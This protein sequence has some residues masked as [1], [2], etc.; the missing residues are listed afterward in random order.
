[1]NAFRRVRSQ[2]FARNVYLF[3]AI[4]LLIGFTLDGGIFSVLFN[5]FLLRL[6]YGTEFVGVVNS[7]GL[8]AFAL[9]SLPAGLWGRRW[10]IK[11]M[12]VLG[13]WI[14]LAGGILLPLAEL[15]ASPWQEW[16]LIG[17]YIAIMTGLAFFFVNSTPFL[18]G[19]VSS[20]ERNRVFALQTA[21]LS[22]AAFVGSLVGGRLPAL[23]AAILGLTT[24]YAAVYR[25]PLLLA[26]I[27]LLPGL[28]M[29]LMTEDVDPRLAERASPEAKEG[30]SRG[31]IGAAPLM[32]LIM[33]VVVRI[34]QVSGVATTSIFY[35]VYLDTDLNVPTTQIGILSA[36]GRLMAV[37]AALLVPWMARRWGNLNL[38]IWACMG[39]A[40]SFLPL[41]LIP[42][43]GAAGIGYI[44]VVGLSALRYPAFIVYAMELVAPEQR[45]TVA[46]SGE[47]A[48]GLIFA[49]IALGGGYWISAF[50]FPTLFLIASLLSAI[51]GL[52][53]WAYFRTIRRDQPVEQTAPV[54]S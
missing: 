35:N 20:S 18:M 52:S 44:G 11:R 10:G 43:W 27:V 41:A 12:L 32:L 29:T 34:F 24:D 33:L 8:L 40:L 22:L 54:I 21:L 9:F 36:L 53:F 30:A 37:V 1:M 42:H 28:L 6:G 17:G 5:L 48:A 3:L 46:G 49:A 19:S 25:Y 31:V 26:G 38:V 50:G 2:T 39:T 23:F 15:L 7:S 16:G 4:E 45:G 47:M 14:M 13:M 51:G